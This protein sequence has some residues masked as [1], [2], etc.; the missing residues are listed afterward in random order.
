[1]QVQIPYGQ[2]KIKVNIPAPCEVLEPNTVKSSRKLN[3][4]CDFQE[5]SRLLRI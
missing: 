5:Q 3:T 1:M 4:E 2:E